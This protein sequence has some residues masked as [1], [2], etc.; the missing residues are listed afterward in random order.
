MTLQ[1]TWSAVSTSMR[2]SVSV[3]RSVTGRPFVHGDAV[4][5]CC[6]RSPDSVFCGLLQSQFSCFQRGRHCHP[7]PQ[8][9]GCKFPARKGFSPTLLQSLLSA[10]WLQW[11]RPLK[12][13]YLRAWHVNKGGFQVP[14]RAFHDSHVRP[15]VWD[16]QICARF[17][18][19]LL[20][21]E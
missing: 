17:Y 3:E 9:R 4:P 10:F 11:A 7:T 8:R 2:T 13:E 6:L 16:A 19:T 20:N 15:F 1:R 18:A 14:H 12:F 21:W 5:R